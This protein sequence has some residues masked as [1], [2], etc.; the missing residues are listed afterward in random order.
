MPRC[1]HLLSGQLELEQAIDVGVRL[2]IVPGRHEEPR[3]RRQ[4][5]EYGLPVGLLLQSP[6][7]RRQE[8][9]RGTEREGVD[10]W[11]HREWVDHRARSTH[12]DQRVA[13]IA[14]APAQRDA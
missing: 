3:C 5:L 11:R 13:A 10:E 14:I 12:E 8:V 1:T 7:Q 9:L 6:E 4:A 2:G